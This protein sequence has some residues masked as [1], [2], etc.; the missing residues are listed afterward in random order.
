MSFIIGIGGGSGAGKTTLALRLKDYF[1]ENVTLIQY[2]NYCKDQS[3]LSLED[4]AKVNYDMPDSYDGELLAE[5]LKLLKQG[6]SI[7]RPTYDFSTHS[8][9]DKYE[10][11]NDNKIIILDGIMI[12]Q[13]KEAID[14]MDLK[15]FVDA[16]EELRLERR[17]KRDIVERGRTRESVIKQFTETVGP[18]HEIWVEPNKE[19]CDIIF[20]NS[21]NN[22]LNENQVKQVIETIVR[23]SHIK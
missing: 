1:K 18:M 6:K 20:D 21:L 4:R 10:T 3:H 19:L 5:H 8:R 17:I 13:V 9:S 7:Q 15:I 16:P 2:D 22:G 23:L 11:I 12:Y 14:N